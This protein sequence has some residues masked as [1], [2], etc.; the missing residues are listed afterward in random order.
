MSSPDEQAPPVDETVEHGVPPSALHHALIVAG[1][2]CR[3]LRR[4]H[5][6]VAVLGALFGVAWLPTLLAAVRSGSLQSASFGE[7]SPVALALG[8]VILPLLGL[9]AGA[10]T[11]AGELEDGTL[12][13]LLTASIS[14]SACYAGKLAGT[15]TSLGIAHV[16]AYGSAACF[17]ALIDGTSGLGDFLVVAAAGL[18]LLLSSVAVGALLA[19][20]G[21]GRVR[22]Y[23]LALLAWMTLVIALDALLL[24]AVI[25]SAPAPPVDVG[26][27]GHDELAASSMQMPA[28]ASD[29]PYPW[30]ML[31]DPVDLYRLTV[32]QTGA[33]LRASWLAGGAAPGSRAAHAASWLGWLFWLVMPAG[34][35]VWRFRRVALV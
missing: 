13:P 21:G 3:M 17:I 1:R 2:E 26:R 23:A 35:G 8:G 31:L 30:F 34:V 9:L 27:H 5:G 28:T 7:V 22:A 6:A 29:A 16:V 10:D 12:V 4:G 19:A 32:L 18:A 33:E 15:A 25:L 24:S 14:R 20:G 11:L